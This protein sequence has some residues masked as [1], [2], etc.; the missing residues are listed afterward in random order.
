MTRDEVFGELYRLQV[1][2]WYE[3]DNNGGRAAAAFYTSDGEFVVGTER[4]AGRA[5][6]AAFYEWRLRRGERTARHLVSNCFLAEVTD[7]SAEFRCIMSL[8]ADDGVPVLPANAPVMI[9]DVVDTCVREGDIWR[10]RSHVLKTVF[11]GGVQPTIPTRSELLTH[12]V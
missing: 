2:Y 5:E 6:I 7:T 9:A 3:V 1:A 10:F 4:M 8:Y 12:K 11:Q